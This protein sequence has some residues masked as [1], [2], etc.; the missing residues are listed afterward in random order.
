MSKVNPDFMNNDFEEFD[1]EPEILT[2]F[3]EDH[4]DQLQEGTGTVLFESFYC[5]FIIYIRLL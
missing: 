1:S 3:T 4:Y 2:E 5:L